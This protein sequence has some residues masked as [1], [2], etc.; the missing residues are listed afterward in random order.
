M[1]RETVG[2]DEERIYT[3]ARGHD[4]RNSHGGAISPDPREEEAAISI[5]C[6]DCHMRHQEGLLPTSCAYTKDMI[7]G[8]FQ[9]YSKMK[10][11]K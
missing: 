3:G 1:L 2:S 4:I 10:I 6:W 7:F 8:V 9:N 11:K 5:T